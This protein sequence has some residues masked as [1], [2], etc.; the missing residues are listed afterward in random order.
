MS[1]L[2][3]HSSE[4]GRLGRS[5]KPS[6][7]KSRRF[8]RLLRDVRF[9]SKLAVLPQDSRILKNSYSFQLRHSVFGSLPFSEFRRFVRPK[10]IRPKIC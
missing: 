10:R 9:V 8:S 5:P 1:I 2:L 6:T 4:N 3:T 7:A